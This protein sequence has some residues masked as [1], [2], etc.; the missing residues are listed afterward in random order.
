MQGVLGSHLQIN[1][2]LR[3]PQPLAKYL[4]GCIQDLDQAKPQVN[5]SDQI[6][7]FLSNTEKNWFQIDWSIQADWEKKEL[8]Q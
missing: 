8:T 5:F 3:H 1:F 4:S 6:L 2:W 7:R